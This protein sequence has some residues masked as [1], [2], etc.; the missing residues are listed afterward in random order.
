[1]TKSKDVG[2]ELGEALGTAVDQLAKSFSRRS[3]RMDAIL[4]AYIRSGQTG[5]SY[6]EERDA[7]LEERGLGTID[8]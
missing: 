1:M 2:K 7:L 3:N 5:R 8:E 4:D 6:Q